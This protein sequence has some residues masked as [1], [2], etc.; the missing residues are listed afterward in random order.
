MKRA[1]FNA[2]TRME[3]KQSAGGVTLAIVALYGGLISIFI[4]IFKHR[5][6]GDT[7]D[8]LEFVA[9]VSS[10]LTLIIGLTEQQKNHGANARE[11]H[12]CARD[13]NDVQKQLTATPIYDPAQLVPFLQR[14]NEIIRACHP[15]HGDVDYALAEAAGTRELS[16]DTTA[17]DR[18]FRRHRRKCR[19]A[20]LINTYWFY[21]IIWFTPAIVGFALW[22]VVP[23]SDSP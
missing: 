14:Y 12:D 8:L 17:Q 10:W 13:I 15:N 16:R 3:R 7:R 11:L 21:V 2:A 6:G 4:M 18:V 23:A 1:R 20:Y 22:L 5:V 19:L 9:V